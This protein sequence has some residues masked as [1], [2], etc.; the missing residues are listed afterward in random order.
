MATPQTD[1]SQVVK[2]L[3]GVVNDCIIVYDTIK[4]AM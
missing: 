4:S 2:T 1:K 3:E